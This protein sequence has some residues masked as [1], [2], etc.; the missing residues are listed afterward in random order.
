MARVQ[1]GG[2]VTKM[3]TFKEY[4]HEDLARDPKFA[5]E[6]IRVVAEDGDPKLLATAIGDVIKASG[7]I[8]KF[9]RETGLN[10]PN[11]QNNLSGKGNP[12]L[13]QI[14]M[15]LDQRGLALTVTPKPKRKKSA[16]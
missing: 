9:S 1:A 3:R 7:G 6:Y 2:E 11:L 8:R 15:V 13:A 5:A 16:A 12:S 4:L 14:A 10:R